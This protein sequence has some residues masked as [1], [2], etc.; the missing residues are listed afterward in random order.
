MTYILSAAVTI[1]MFW[2]WKVTD[3]KKSLHEINNKLTMKLNS[4]DNE[5]KIIE[6]ELLL[7][8]KNK[9]IYYM[10]YVLDDFIGDFTI[11]TEKKDL[12]KISF[13][14][15]SSNVKTEFKLNREQNQND[16]IIVSITGKADKTFET[17]IFDSPAKIWSK[18]QDS[19]VEL[20]KQ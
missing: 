6:S 4:A 1:L 17:S 20:K 8:K 18:I 14:Y 7:L 15:D 11:F 19:I 10:L 13:E 12:M 16:I 9:A 2:L 5:K 3:E